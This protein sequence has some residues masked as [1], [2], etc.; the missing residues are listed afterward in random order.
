MEKIAHRKSL[1]PMD[2]PTSAHEKLVLNVNS[3]WRASKVDQVCAKPE[4]SNEN[5]V[6]DKLR[7]DGIEKRTA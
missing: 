5:D 4:R 6:A 7:K 1:G 3:Y 2:G